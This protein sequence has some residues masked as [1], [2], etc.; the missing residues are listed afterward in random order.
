MSE[1]DRRIDVTQG[2]D[3]SFGIFFAFVCFTF[4]GYFFF[5]GESVIW[6]F[7]LIIGFVL[8]LV[9]CFSPKLLSAP[10][11]YWFKLG[12]GLGAFFSPLIMAFVYLIAVIPVGLV[13]KTIGKDLIS[14]KFDKSANSYWVVRAPRSRSMKDQ[15]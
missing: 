3:K 8:F 13:A 10:N 1:Y 11:N 12:L 6:I 15:F 7:A 5:R 4:G 2:S 9:A 14:Q